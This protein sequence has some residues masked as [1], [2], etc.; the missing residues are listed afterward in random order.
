M[1][2]RCVAPGAMRHPKLVWL[3]R[4]ALLLMVV[5]SAAQADTRGKLSGRI[6]DP[7]GQP[8]VGATVV[9]LGTRKSVV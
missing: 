4:T 7:K 9:I 3:I 2:Q 1:D 6:A 5:A 8:V